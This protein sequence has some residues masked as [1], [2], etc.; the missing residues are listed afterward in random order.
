MVMLLNLAEHKQHGEPLRVSS[1]SWHTPL[2]S[3]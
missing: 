3:H 1:F 2:L